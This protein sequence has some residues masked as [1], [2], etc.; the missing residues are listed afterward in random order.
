MLAKELEKI[1]ADSPFEALKRVDEGG[2]EYWYARELMSLFGYSSWRSFVE[3]LR[4]AYKACVRSG[5]DAKKHFVVE[6]KMIAI[7]KGAKRPVLEIRLTRYACYLTAQNASS[8]FK[9]V[10]LAQTYFAVQT[11]K[12]EIIEQLPE[13]AKRVYIRD[14]VTDKNK[15]LAGDARK[16]GVVN[17]AMFNDAGYKGPYGMSLSDIERIKGISKGELLDRS[18]ATELAANLFRITQ[19]SEKLVK[20]KVVGQKAAEATHET[21]GRKVRSTIKQIGGVMPE[22]L[23]AERNIKQLRRELNKISSPKN[24]Q[25]K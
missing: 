18:G 12:Q 16:S 6:R 5:Q 14:Q 11:R 20:D 10:S 15:R 19:T 1:D 25:I 23:P 17:F 4:K 8:S 3:V 21:V 9:E 7:G 22:L 2:V 24:K 13:D